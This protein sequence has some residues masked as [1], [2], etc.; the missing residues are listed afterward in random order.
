MGPYRRLPA[1][2]FLVYLGKQVNCKP[3]TLVAFYLLCPLDFNRDIDAAFYKQRR[4]PSPIKISETPELAQFRRNLQKAQGT[5]SSLVLIEK[6]ANTHTYI[7]M[8]CLFL[9]RGG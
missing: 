4:T 5:P 8:L 3:N 7:Y 2:E 1:Q 9:R 6:G